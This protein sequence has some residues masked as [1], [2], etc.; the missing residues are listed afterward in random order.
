MACQEKQELRHSAQEALHYI[1][2]RGIERAGFNYDA[3][4]DDFLTRRLEL[5]VKL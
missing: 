5:Y 2:I 3:D 4:R 1:I